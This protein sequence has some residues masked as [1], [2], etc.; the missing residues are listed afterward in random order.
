MPRFRVMGTLTT[1]WYAEVEA[2]DPEEARAKINGDSDDVEFTYDHDYDSAEIDTVDC[3]DELPTEVN[4]PAGTT[5]GWDFCPVVD[6]FQ[7]RGHEGP[8]GREHE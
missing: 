3:L 2:A 6:C 4:P 1:Y 7:A 8:H 5:V